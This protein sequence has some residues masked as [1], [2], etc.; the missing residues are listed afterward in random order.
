[1]RRMFG[2]L[3]TCIPVCSFTKFVQSD[4]TSEILLLQRLAHLSLT[5]LNSCFITK[6]DSSGISVFQ[7][8]RWLELSIQFYVACATVHNL[9]PEGFDT[10]H[11]SAVDNSIIAE[12]LDC[13]GPWV[14][15][16][17]LFYLVAKKCGWIEI[18]KIHDRLDPQKYR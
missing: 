3:E 12:V 9:V 7:V 10:S 18:C 14:A 13:K 16:H 8:Y 15:L 4:M 11:G 2:L 6:D 5:F 17:E 1:M